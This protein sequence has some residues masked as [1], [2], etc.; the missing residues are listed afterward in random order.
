MSICRVQGTR[1]TKVYIVSYIMSVLIIFKSNQI[2]PRFLVPGYLY[3][4]S[5]IN[6]TNVCCFS[7]PCSFYF[8]DSDGSSD[9]VIVAGVVAG[10]VTS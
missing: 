3:L 10:L 7:I 8:R 2:F 6:Y 1:G 5:I 9:A 4:S